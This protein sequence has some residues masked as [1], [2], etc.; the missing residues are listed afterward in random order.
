MDE[1][2]VAV[3]AVGKPTSGSPKRERT[4]SSLDAPDP[5]T[6]KEMFPADSVRLANVDLPQIFRIY[7]DL[8]GRTMIASPALP[9][10]KVSLH[11]KTALLRREVLQALDT[12]LAQHQITV[13]PMGTD[14]VKAVPMAQAAMEAGPA[15][16]LS[17][18]QLPRSD[19]YLT[20]IVR[21]KHASPRE[22]A[23]ALAPLARMPGS[24]IMVVE[25]SGLLVLRDYSNNVR[26]MLQLL[27]KIDVPGGL[28]RS[29]RE[30]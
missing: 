24:S 19:S 16:D 26:H 20:Y 14:F 15:V 12:V 8:S 28:P 30:K 1:P 10:A 2:P 13:I 7:E 3:V 11:L 5:A 25:G 4:F 23:P 6:D 22:M 27:D 17:P 18:D 29:S 9:P 21:L